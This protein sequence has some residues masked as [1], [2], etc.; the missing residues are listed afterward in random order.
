MCK[1][2]LDIQQNIRGGKAKIKEVQSWTMTNLEL[3]KP[4]S[5]K[6]I[7]WIVRHENEIIKYVNS[8]GHGRKQIWRERGFA[9]DEQMKL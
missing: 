8:N 9:L 2:E 3:H 5:F 7:L 4:P 6:T 1:Q